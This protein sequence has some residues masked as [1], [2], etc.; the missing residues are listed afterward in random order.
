MGLMN[1]A[2]QTFMR[3]QMQQSLTEEQRAFMDAS[4]SW[5]LVVFGIAVITGFL[6]CVGLILKKAWSI[7]LFLVSL[8][9]IIIQMGYNWIQGGASVFDTL[10]GI[11]MPILVIVIAWFLHYYSKSAKEKAWIT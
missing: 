6:G 8:V 3:E 9:A 11:V 1:F 7:N 2:G 4:P 5:I 10:N